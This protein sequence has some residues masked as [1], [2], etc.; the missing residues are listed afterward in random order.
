MV[1]HDLKAPLRTIQTLASWL[2][3]DYQDQLDEVGREH[4]Q[5]MVSRPGHGARFIFTLLKSRTLPTAK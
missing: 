1:S 2:Q 3:E 4:L 5:T